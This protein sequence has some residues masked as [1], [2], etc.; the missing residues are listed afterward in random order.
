MKTPKTDT[1]KISLPGEFSVIKNKQ[2]VSMIIHVN[3][4]VH[5]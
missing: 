3:T 5:V 4:R 2:G 1:G